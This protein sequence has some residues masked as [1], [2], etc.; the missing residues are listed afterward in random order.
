ME[1]CINLQ[2]KVGEKMLYKTNVGGVSF[3]FLLADTAS[4]SRATSILQGPIEEVSKG[5]PLSEWMQLCAKVQGMVSGVWAAHLIHCTI[6]N[7]MLSGLEC[8]PSL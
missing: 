1:N 5:H 4:G 2:R 8:Q 3:P 6:S 7:A